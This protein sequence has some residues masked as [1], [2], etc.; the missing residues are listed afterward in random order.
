MKIFD[1]IIER[2]HTNCYKWDSLIEKYG[3]NNDIIPMGVADMDFASS[4]AIQK[5]LH[6]KINERA[7][8]YIADPLKDLGELIISRYRQRGY[9]VSK[10][11]IVLSTGVVHAINNAIRAFSKENDTIILPA[12][13]YTPFQQ[14]IE[15]N[16]RKMLLC[17]MVIRNGRYEMDLETLEKQ[18]DEQTRLFILCNPHNPTGRIYDR[19]EL[20]QLAEFAQR[21]QLMIISD[22]IHA[23]FS[24]HKEVFPM[25]EV[26]EYARNHTLTFLSATKTFNLAGLKMSFGFITDPKLRQIFH[27]Q[28]LHTGLESVNSLAVSAVTAAYRDSS[29]WEKELVDYLRTNCDYAVGFIRQKLPEVRVY[30]NEGTYLLWLDMRDCGIPFEQ[31]NDYLI[32]HARVQLND[33]SHYGQAFA[34]YQRMNCALPL[35]QLKEALSRIEK[36]LHR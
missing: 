35:S 10:E 31:L 9:H 32:K 5:A 12:P 23:D 18:V 26:N 7:F 4:Q 16:G 25:M 36:A 8:G 27:Q 1:E 11:D 28:S 34:G 6:D 3:E 22:E 13:Y 20:E 2:R 15:G 19:S 14:L 30:P 24:L 21:H 29:E 33:G 17:P